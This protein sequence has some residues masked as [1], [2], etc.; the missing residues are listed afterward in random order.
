MINKMLTDC[1]QSHAAFTH[2]VYC[3]IG[4]FLFWFAVHSTL[5]HHVDFEV[6]WSLC[7]CVYG[8]DQTLCYTLHCTRRVQLNMSL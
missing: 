7:V 4:T 6:I 3:T 2:I 8:N 1:I 5:C